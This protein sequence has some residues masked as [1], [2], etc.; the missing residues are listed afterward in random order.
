M[1]KLC[2]WLLEN[3]IN[4]AWIWKFIEAGV[5]S[6]SGARLLEWAIYTF[7]F[8]IGTYLY[9]CLET[10]TFVD[11]RATLIVLGVWFGKTILESFLKFMRTK[12][13]SYNNES[14]DW[15]M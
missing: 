5:F 7:Y 1:I 4:L 11:F 3:V 15:G 14:N 6:A 8:G 9:K 12:K 13:N 10:G 2:K